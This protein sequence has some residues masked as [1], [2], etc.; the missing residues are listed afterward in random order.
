MAATGAACATCAGCASS[1]SATSAGSSSTCTASAR[2]ARSSCAASST[3]S[4]QVDGELRALERALDDRRDILELREP[5]IAACPRCGALHGS[6][7]R[8]CPSC[9]VPFSGPRAMAEVGEGGVQAVGEIGAVAPAV[10]ATSPIEQTAETVVA[11]TPPPTEPLQPTEHTP[12]PVPEPPAEP[13]APEPET[14]EP[15]PEPPASVPDPEPVASEPEPGPVEP[16]A[17]L[18]E[19]EPR[20]TADQPTTEQPALV[21]PEDEDEDGPRADPHD[22]LPSGIQP[23]ASSDLPGEGESDPDAEEPGDRAS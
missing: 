16:E 18:L 9:G 13:V 15:E 14:P 11:E 10:E 2:K 6:D 19:P 7:A 3:R 5:G 21:L 8:F 1:A 12:A 20:V 4:G 23:S 17:P 22:W